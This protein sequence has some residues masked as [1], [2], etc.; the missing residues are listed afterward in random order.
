MIF[1]SS[2]QSWQQHFA[3]GKFPLIHFVTEIQI[4][5]FSFASLQTNDPCNKDALPRSRFFK[6]I[7]RNNKA[8][9]QD[10]ELGL[11]GGRM[12]GLYLLFFLPF[13][14]SCHVLLHRLSIWYYYT[15]QRCKQAA[16]LAA[17]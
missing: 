13:W 7:R 12:L 6:Q 10:W 5:Y 3:L 2:G 1:L 9:P 16:L 8:K 14:G 11:K 17:K 4:P 15:Y